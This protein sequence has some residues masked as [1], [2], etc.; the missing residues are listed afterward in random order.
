VYGVIQGCCKIEWGAVDLLKDQRRASH[1]RSQQRAN[2]PYLLAGR[3]FQG[4]RDAA[5]RSS[6]PT[7]RTGTSCS[8][9]TCTAREEFTAK[10]LRRSMPG[11]QHILPSS[12]GPGRAGI[13]QRLSLRRKVFLRAE[14]V[15][16]RETR[17]RIEGVCGPPEQGFDSIRAV[18]PEED[19]V[20]AIV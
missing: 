19:A 13:T 11:D 15:R 12:A 7:S 9:I 8:S 2:E 1:G 16:C 14:R 17:M 5:P 18:S 10:V 20:L 6:R 4:E 3:S